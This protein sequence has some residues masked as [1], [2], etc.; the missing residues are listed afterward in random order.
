MHEPEIVS[1]K[2]IGEKV[3]K[4]R[5]KVGLSQERLAEILSVSYQQVQRYENGSN[6]LNVENLQLIAQALMVP[7]AY[8]F[9]EQYPQSVAETGPVYES[10]EEKN[11][12]R[13]FRKI[14]NKAGRRMVVDVARL[15]AKKQPS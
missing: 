13:H 14:D 15:A 7:V 11:L 4:R 1:S 6:K 12:I 8:F 9:Q 10:E 3:R 5:Q 2:E